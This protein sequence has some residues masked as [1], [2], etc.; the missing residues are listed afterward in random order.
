MNTAKL[1]QK[2]RRELTRVIRSLTVVCAVWFSSGL[3][4]MGVAHE[5]SCGCESSRVCEGGCVQKTPRK[6]PKSLSFVE[7]ILKHF[8]H[9]GDKIE[10]EHRLRTTARAFSFHRGGPQYN[11]G[12]GL[13]RGCETDASGCGCHV[14]TGQSTAGQTINRPGQAFTDE[15]GNPPPVGQSLPNA[16]MNPNTPAQ[17]QAI[18]KI[19]DKSSSRATPPS[20]PAANTPSTIPSQ[21]PVKKT[22]PLDAP[23]V[24]HP[25]PASGGDAKSPT[26]EPAPMPPSSRQSVEPSEPSVGK[27]APAEKPESAIEPFTP[28]F[29]KAASEAPS[30]RNIP[31]ESPSTG[32]PAKR[33]AAALPPASLPPA[34]L[35]PTGLPPAAL[36]P[37]G[38]PS[39]KDGQIPDVLVDPFQDDVTRE[40]KGSRTNAIKLTIGADRVSG[41]ISPIKESKAV[42]LKSVPKEELDQPLPIILT[43]AGPIETG[44][45]VR[46]SYSEAFPVI[47]KQA[48]KAK[49]IHFNNS[50]DDAP[51][52][53]R[54]PVPTPK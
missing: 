25:G 11:T 7:K 21:I 1:Q 14:C 9:I 31:T 23:K 27:T 19:S 50:E 24:E 46:S 43:P 3:E 48:P 4:L 53:R 17:K 41:P 37:A 8:D 38:L 52:V 20:V 45:V 5:P 36:P 35:P 15:N 22:E 13:T 2:R 51:T 12:I 34:N 47:R 54:K 10:A 6:K 28:R 44:D 30:L 26:D 16:P 18:G 49:V 29:P 40:G 33:P 42:Q 32:Y 39:S